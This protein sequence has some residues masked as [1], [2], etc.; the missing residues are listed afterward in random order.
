M[1]NA[2][3]QHFGNHPYVWERNPLVANGV[4]NLKETATAIEEA[5]KNI[6]T[7]AQ[8]YNL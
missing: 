4:N 8:R 2:V 5:A 7:C 6:K 3:I 1:T